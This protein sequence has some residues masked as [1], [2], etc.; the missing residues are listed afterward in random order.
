MLVKFC[1]IT[2][3]LKETRDTNEM[4]VG[5][6]QGSLQSHEMELKKDGEEIVEKDLQTRLNLR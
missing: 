6:L 3:V 1:S 5:E 4:T 2:M